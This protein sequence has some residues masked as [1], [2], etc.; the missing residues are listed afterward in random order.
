MMKLQEQAEVLQKLLRVFDWFP[1]WSLCEVAWEGVVKLCRHARTAT[2]V[3]V[4]S[5][6][7]LVDCDSVAVCQLL[8]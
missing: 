6:L 1:S 8:L 4:V 5:Q 7:L 3:P 2:A